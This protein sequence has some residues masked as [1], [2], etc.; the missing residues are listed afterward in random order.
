MA[1]P[2]SL[3]HTIDG[4]QVWVQSR[5]SWLLLTGDSVRINESLDALEQLWAA[6]KHG[7]V[8][9]ISPSMTPT[10]VTR[11]CMPFIHGQSEATREDGV[12]PENGVCE[13]SASR[14]SGLIIIHNAH[15]L[16]VDT[17]AAITQHFSACHVVSAVPD[18]RQTS[19]LDEVPAVILDHV[20]P[21]LSTPYTTD[22]ALITALASRFMPAGAS[23][24]TTVDEVRVTDERGDADDADIGT[25]NSDTRKDD[26]QAVEGDDELSQWVARALMSHLGSEATPGLLLDAIYG[27]WC[28]HAQAHHGTHTRSYCRYVHP[29]SAPRG[30]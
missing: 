8:I 4:L 23:R 20:G 15:L 19:T 28:A 16:E 26:V 24:T 2:D 13:S 17:A 10:D 27:T 11:V 22:P 30:C 9:R 29:A 18:S 3:A 7:S 12:A 21:I 5:P 25:K 1:H 6:M 14:G